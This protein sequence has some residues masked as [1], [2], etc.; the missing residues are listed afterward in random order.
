[1]RA[2]VE[3]GDFEV[4]ADEPR[5][6]GGADTGPQPTDLFLASIASCFVLAV[7]WAARKRGVELPD[8]QVRVVGTYDGP[9]FSHIDIGVVSGAAPAVLEEL[10]PQAERV[11]YVTNT[12]RRPPRI[13]VGGHP[14]HHDVS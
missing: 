3:A 1:M 2:L 13:R 4:V 7:A 12:L 10:L 8:L 14:V 9:R 6:A 5:S 11:C